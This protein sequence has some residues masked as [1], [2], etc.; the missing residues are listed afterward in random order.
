MKA[1]IQMKTSNLL[2]SNKCWLRSLNTNQVTGVP[3]IRKIKVIL[4]N[5]KV[6]VTHLMWNKSRSNLI[7][8]EDFE[9]HQLDSI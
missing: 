4:W 5:T 1:E 2:E 6:I 7:K 3:D 9:K 8:R